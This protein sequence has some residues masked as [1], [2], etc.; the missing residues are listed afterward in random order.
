[1]AIKFKKLSAGGGSN[2]TPIEVNELP[3]VGVEGIIYKKNTAP[4][5]YI[6]DN[7]M[8]TSMKEIL[9]HEGIIITDIEIV[10]ILPTENIKV[11]DMTT[12]V[13]PL[14]YSK[15]DSKVWGYMDGTWVDFILFMF[16]VDLTAQLVY[17]LDNITYP[18]TEGEILAYV[19]VPSELYKYI[20]GEYV[21]IDKLPVINSQ[22]WLGTQVSS[23]EKVEKVYL[24]TA[25]SREEVEAILNEIDFIEYD[26]MGLYYCVL[27]NDSNNGFYIT[28][29]SAGS[30]YIKKGGVSGGGNNVLYDTNMGW[31][32]S[33]ATTEYE[34]TGENITSSFASEIGQTMQNDKLTQL[35]S[36]T[37]FTKQV[38]LSGEY[39][40][41]GTYE[42]TGNQT[43]DLTATYLKDKEI[44]L[45]IKINVDKAEWVLHKNF[46]TELSDETIT[47]IGIYAANSASNLE[48]INFP[49]VK[50]INQGA[51]GGCTKLSKINI[52]NV[53]TIWA[54]AFSHCHAL[55][56][57]KLANINRVSDHAFTSCYNLESVDLGSDL[58]TLGEV[59]F[60]S[61]YSLKKLV[62]RRE[63]AML[64]W[65]NPLSYCYHFDGTVD[66]TYNPN[67]DKDGYI[68]V[69]DAL[70]D[71]YKNDVGTT[72]KGWNQYADQIKPLSEY[73]ED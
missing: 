55:T 21:K 63:D 62:I 38:T 64:T 44:P 56:S 66:E 31:S 5:I 27:C 53:T 14:Y 34:F 28:K 68:Y 52:P 43:I 33:Y 67:G 16:K 12:G 30:Y 47:E 37:P 22:E 71:T 39:V 50:T 32:I 7:S 8:S 40:S 26:L 29:T 18:T 42:F 15:Q 35:F 59:A 24:N 51:F 19:V 4:D 46:I 36:T 1:M 20:K 61:C 6:A 11:V 60:L 13:A 54:S 72:G 70:V 58:H 57:L 2:G 41:A 17:G 45:K 23:Y 25:L 9:A 69:P 10:D 65:Y 3:S 49:N 48:S 73:V